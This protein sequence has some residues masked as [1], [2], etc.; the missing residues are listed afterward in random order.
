MKYYKKNFFYFL[1]LILSFQIFKEQYQSQKDDL[2]FKLR[3]ELKQKADRYSFQKIDLE[4]YNIYIMALLGVI[5]LFTI[6]IISFTIFEIIN[7]KRK[8]K[9]ELIKKTIIRNSFDSSKLSESKFLSN[10]KIKSNI[11]YSRNSNLQISKESF[12]TGQKKIKD[13][14]NSS[15]VYDSGRSKEEKDYACDNKDISNN[16]N[17]KPNLEDSSEFRN[18]LSS[19]YE[20]PIVENFDQKNNEEKFLTNEG[21]EED[22]QKIIFLNNPY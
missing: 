12:S 11:I 16:I 9:E 1:I 7:C 13:S 17:E 19:G 22:K 8:K 2:I 3:E 20:A 14:F 18:R 5:I 4:L 15:N 6:I 21:N 10:S